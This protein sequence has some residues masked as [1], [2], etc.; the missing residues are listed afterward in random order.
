MVEQ[1]SPVV[2]AEATVSLPFE[3]PEQQ[4]LFL[5]KIDPTQSSVRL[6]IKFL[7]VFTLSKIVI[8]LVH[9]KEHSSCPYQIAKPITYK[10]CIDGDVGFKGKTT[11]FEEVDFLHNALPEL[12]VNDIDSSSQ[13]AGLP[14]QGTVVYC[15]YDRRC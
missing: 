5:E 12:H 9:C 7:K 1:Q 4:R 6:T 8:R 11:L 10:L 14:L 3:E 15:S 13:F 2:Q